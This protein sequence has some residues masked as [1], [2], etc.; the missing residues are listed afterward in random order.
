MAGIA[1]GNMNI[2]AKSTGVVPNTELVVVK[3]KQSKK[4]IR[5]FWKIPEGPPCFQQN[6]IMFGIY[7]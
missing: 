5:E 6:D 2:S 7:L 4:F 3:L 1:A